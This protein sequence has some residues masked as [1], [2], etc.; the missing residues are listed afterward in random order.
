MIHGAAVRPPGDKDQPAA[1]TRAVSAPDD[2]TPWRASHRG[3]SR[4]PSGHSLGRSGLGSQRGEQDDLLDGG[5]AGEEHGQAV[6]ADPE[7]AAGRHA[8][9]QG[10]EVV[11][12]DRAG[13]EVAGLLGQL[14]GLEPRSLLDGV[15]QLAVGVGQLPAAHDQLEALDQPGV[16][17]VGPGQRGDL[18]RVV[19][20]ERGCPQGRL[21]QGV[22]QRHAHR[23]RAHVGL[24]D[25]VVLLGDRPQ[26]VE[27]HRGVHRCPDLLGDELEH[28]RPAPG[29]GQV[30]LVAVDR[31]DR[32][33]EGI[34]SGVHDHALGQLHHVVV[35][36]EGLVGLEHRELGV[37]PRRDALVAED[38]ADLVD[39]LEATDDEPLEVQLERDAEVELHVE[40]VVERGERPGVGAPR[41]HVQHRR[42]HLDEAPRV[43]APA[44]RCDDGVAHGEAPARLLVDDEVDVALPVPGVDVGEAPPLVGQRPEGLGQQLEG[45]D[46]HRQL[47][48]AGGHDG[49]LDADP[50][51]EVEVVELLVG[52]A[53]HRPG[54]EQLHLAVAVAQRREGQLALAPQQHDAPGHPDALVGLGAR[55]ELA[56]RCPQLG[57]RLG[58]VEPVRVGLDTL[59]AAGLE[60]RQPGGAL[61]RQ[62]AGRG[63]VGAVGLGRRRLAGRALG[64]RAKP[65]GG[66]SA[67]PAELRWA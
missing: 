40:G 56:V 16:V 9:L 22:V 38:P 37:V 32:R 62:P 51:A 35:V 65:T 34:A 17:A 50:V 12:V 30:D 57:E 66:A 27:G 61:D 21:D 43:Q 48:L 46:L 59:R 13:L 63:I 58:A 53:E 67:R 29:H 7:A 45:L 55:R 23:A 25:D 11:L 2:S 3:R 24:D 10:A 42:L 19:E 14:L 5:H 8:V 39:A 20:D 4:C 41:L 28:R 47:A 1:A 54:D 60:L 49:S 52:V 31:D 36:G 26:V 44:Q 33:A 64:H 6:D 15:V 18:H